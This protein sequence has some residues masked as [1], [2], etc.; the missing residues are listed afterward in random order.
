MIHAS[1]LTFTLD[2]VK[3]YSIAVF[4]RHTDLGRDT[5]MNGGRE[6]ERKM[7]C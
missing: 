6:R 3:Y 5:E 1:L 2:I 7:E 4:L